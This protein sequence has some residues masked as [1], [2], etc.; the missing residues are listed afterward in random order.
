MLLRRIDDSV[1]SITCLLL[2][3]YGILLLKHDI[4][5]MHGVILLLEAPEIFD[6]FLHLGL[7]ANFVLLKE[8]LTFLK[9]P[10]QSSFIVLKLL[11]L[12][13]QVIDL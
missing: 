13:M 10:E 5:L 7:Q 3:V 9:I 6:L 8:N 1:G 12:V 2:L 11:G 4:L